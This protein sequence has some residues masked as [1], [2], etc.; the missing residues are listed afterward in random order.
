MPR[1][2]RASRVGLLVMLLVV[3]LGSL[4]VVYTL[5]TE[6]LTIAG[7]IRTGKVDAE[8]SLV[9]CL[10]LEADK[11]VGRTRAEIDGA[12]RE[13]LRF[14]IENGYPG[15]VGDC[16]VEYHYIGSV[17]A[18]VESITFVPGSELTDCAVSQS[19][20]TGSLTATCDQLTVKWINGLC[21]QLHRGDEMASSLRVHVEQEAAQDFRYTFSI[22]VRLVQ[23]NES[24]CP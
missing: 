13:T 4:A 10:D 12:S 1:P 24:S 11:D 20:T 9:G 21:A 6:T 5:W 8:W 14:A 15:Y 16:E 2:W 7:T 17:P 22:F 3:A 19:P 23:W 18:T